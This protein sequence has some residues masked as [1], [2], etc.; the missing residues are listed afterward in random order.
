MLPIRSVVVT[1]FIFILF[2]SLAIMYG[3][4]HQHHAFYIPALIGSGIALIFAI[5]KLKL[6]LDERYKTPKTERYNIQ[7]KSCPDGWKTIHQ[8]KNVICDN[9]ANDTTYHDVRIDHQRRIQNWPRRMNL[10]WINKHRTNQQKCSLGRN[11]AWTELT[12]KCIPIEM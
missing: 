1:T 4:T 11:M 12:N 8:D 10:T 5:I 3:G 6:E 9:Q 2:G 7:L